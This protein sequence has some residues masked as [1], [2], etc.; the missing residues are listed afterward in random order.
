M[1]IVVLQG[2]DTARARARYTQIIAGVKK[3]N[4]DVVPIQVAKPL[5]EQ[6]VSTNLFTT[7]ILY[8]IDGIKKLKSE[9]LKWLSKNADKYEGSLLVFVEGKVPTL[10]RNALPKTAK[11]ETFDLPVLVWQFVDSFYPG[12]SKKSLVL[13]EKVIATEA[14]EFVVAMLARQLRDLYWVVNGAKGM[15]AS[16]WRQAKIEKQKRKVTKAG[17]V[18]TI[19][20]L[21]ELDYKSKTSDTDTKLMLEMLIIEKLV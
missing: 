20:S 11:Y 10:F 5:P 9:E 3:K 14:V 15:S 2:D 16:S 8:S 1:K 13:F 18:D 4:W 21:A 12:N 7:D 19:D 6:L 17:L